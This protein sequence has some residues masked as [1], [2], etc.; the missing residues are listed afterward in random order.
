MELAIG[1]SFHGASR[2]EQ[3]YNALCYLSLATIGNFSLMLYP[4]ILKKCISILSNFPNSILLKRLVRYSRDVCI[5]VS[6]LVFLN[7]AIKAS[8]TSPDHH[9]V[10]FQYYLVEPS[11]F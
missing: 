6:C 10:H 11:R 1:M 7:N 4:S 9:F 8:I 2:T 5:A 3:F